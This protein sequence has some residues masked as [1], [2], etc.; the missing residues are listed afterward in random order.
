MFKS[1][2]IHH[3]H[4]SDNDGSY[5]MHH[6][7]GS[8]NIDFPKIFDILKQKKYDDICVIEVRT[9][10]GILKSIDYLKDINIL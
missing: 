3:I 10:Q 2:N 8:H 1:D 7:L 9:L 4:L 5:D 6:A